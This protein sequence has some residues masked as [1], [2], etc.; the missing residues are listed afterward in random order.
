MLQEETR[1]EGWMLQEGTREEG[2]I[3]QVEQNHKQKPE[4]SHDN[5]ET[6][7]LIIAKLTSHH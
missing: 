6:K 4:Q 3:L 2:L 7:Q 1:E 5:S